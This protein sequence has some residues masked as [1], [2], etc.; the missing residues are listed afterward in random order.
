M[1]TSLS[2]K[3]A[4]GFGFFL[5]PHMKQKTKEA[6]SIIMKNYETSIHKTFKKRNIPSD[7][8]K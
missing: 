6:F 3:T 4:R 7:H 1:N 2:L 8:E 5:N